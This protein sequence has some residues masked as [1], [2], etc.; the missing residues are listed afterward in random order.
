VA[1]VLYVAGTLS[2]FASYF[3]GRAAAET[4]WMPGM[5]HAAIKVHWDWAFRAVSFFAVTTALR[6][7]LLWWQRPAPKPAA[8][9]V[10]ALAGLVGV[11]LIVETADRGAQLVYKHSVGIARE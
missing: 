7:L 5:A 8:L 4:V 6:L 2:L 1:T 10:L 3:T 9:G 11:F